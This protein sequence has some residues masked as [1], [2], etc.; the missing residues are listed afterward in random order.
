MP[1][2]KEKTD[3][4]HKNSSAVQEYQYARR[5]LEKSGNGAADVKEERGKLY[6]EMSALEQEKDVRGRGE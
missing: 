2:G 5:E 4:Y 6:E 3:F 1:E